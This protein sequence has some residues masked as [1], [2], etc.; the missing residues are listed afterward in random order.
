MNCNFSW[1]SLDQKSTY[2]HKIS[3]YLFSYVED[4]LEDW[5]NDVE[6]RIQFGVD[7]GK[8]NGWVLSGIILS[9][10]DVILIFHIFLK[11]HKI[12]KSYC[13][14]YWLAKGRWFIKH[15]SY[16]VSKIGFYKHKILNYTFCTT[17]WTTT[18]TTFFCL[19]C[20]ST[21]KWFIHKLTN[22]RKINPIEKNMAQSTQ[23]FLKQD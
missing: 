17:K 13:L 19:F 9:K 6:E 22:I 1:F 8:R 7:F 14:Y 20:F 2:V 23:F 4:R 16:Y 12:W 10:V 21:V 3:F 18:S 11:V 5:T 15:H